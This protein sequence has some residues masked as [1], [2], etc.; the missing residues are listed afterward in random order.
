ML[1]SSPDPSTT[2]TLRAS[3]T[4]DR[5]LI[6]VEDECGGLPDGNVNALFQPFEQ[7]GADRTGLGLGLAISRWG[8]EAN[9]G[10]ISARNLPGHGCIFIIDLPRAAVP[11]PER[12]PGCRTSGVTG[13]K[14]RGVFER[15][16]IVNSGDL[17][18]AA[19]RLGS[20]VRQPRTSGLYQSFLESC[21]AATVI[22]IC[23]PHRL[24]A[25]VVFGDEPPQLT[26][27]VG[28]GGED[29]TGGEIAFHPGEPELHLVESEAISSGRGASTPPTSAGPQRCGWRAGWL[30]RPAGSSRTA[31]RRARHRP[32]A[33]RCRRL[34]GQGL[35]ELPGNWRTSERQERL[36]DARRL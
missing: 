13:H 33:S 22:G 9:N 27:E 4:P 18:E 2:V 11:S 7:R 29:A 12:Q 20:Q 25:V 8:A 1:S 5:V 26:R 36:V 16:N 32:F 34:R 14:T 10:R 17:R 28:H 6:E 3:A 35:Q 15:Y 23:P 21:D 24:R 30:R 19:R 31:C